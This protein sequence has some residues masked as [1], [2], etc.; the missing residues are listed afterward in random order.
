MGEQKHPADARKRPG[1][2][3]NDDEGIEPGL[4]VHNNEEISKN[5]RAKQS[6]AQAYEGSGHGL[7]LTAN[8][9]AAAPRQFFFNVVDELCDPRRNGTK[10][11]PGD[12]G[13]DIN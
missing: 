1:Q 5:N 3:G 4:E 7:N 12:R 9:D 13:V 8:E 10:I 6:N 2:R 11:A